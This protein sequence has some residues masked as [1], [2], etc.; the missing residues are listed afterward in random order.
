MDKDIKYFDESADIEFTKCSKIDKRPIVVGMGPCGIFAAYALAKSGNPPIILERG[1]DVHE[2]VLAIK[3]FRKFGELDPNSN[4][5]FGEGGAGTFSDGKLNTRISDPRQRFVLKTFVE[6]GAP[7]DIMYKSKPHIGTDKLRGVLKA[8]RKSLINM[9]TI[10][11]F[12][13]RL[14]DIE[15]KDGKVTGV[16][17]NDSEK[18]ECDTLVMAIGHS[19]R[20]TYEMLYKNGINMEQ[21]AFAIGVRIEHRQEKIDE[22]QYGSSKLGLPAAEYRVTYNGKDRSCYS[23]CMCPG[24]SVINA[25]SEDGGLVV[26]GMSEH[27]R[28]G[29]NA[30]S[31]LVVN[32]NPSD[33]GDDSPLAGVEFQRKYERLAFELGGGDYT[34]PVQLAKDFIRDRVSTGLCGVVP[35]CGEKYMFAELKKCLPTFVVDTLKTGIRHFEGKMP[36]FEK[37]GAVL[38][39]VE[40]RTSAPLRILRN[41]DFES[42]NISG[43]YPA[44]EGAG[45]AGG[46]VSAAVDGI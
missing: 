31:A 28:N 30:N 21:K 17:I 2:R 46:I 3:K 38:V 36:G 7:A 40:T 35:S 32:V 12:N 45:Y 29:E 43:L 25:S 4:V 27:S 23:F 5:Q 8:M 15:I 9:G 33:F 41:T 42:V 24:G 39:G 1:G 37:G 26:N 10:I 44:G 11:K 6:N 19:S 22:L 16:I 14:T 13:T 34:V 18:I 20:D